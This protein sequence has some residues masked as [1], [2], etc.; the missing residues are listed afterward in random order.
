MTPALPQTHAEIEELLG[1]YALDAVDPETAAVIARHLEECVR[2][3]VEVAQ[4]HEVA[5]MLANSGG[6]P[7][8]AVW[9][10][11]VDANGPGSLGGAAAGGG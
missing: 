5:G 2:C 7:S 3:S 8:S 4:H 9:D 11:S 1:A 6:A 10:A